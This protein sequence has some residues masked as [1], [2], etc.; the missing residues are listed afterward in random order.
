MEWF[1]RLGIGRKLGIGFG[2]MAL[3]I[4]IVGLDG[5]RTSRRMNE[6]VL[7]LHTEHAVPAMKLKDASLNLVRISRAVRNAIIDEDSVA[8][9]GRM[10]EIRKS[11][12]L[13]KDAFAAFREHIV[14]DVTK[15]QAAR[16]ERRVKILRPQQDAVVALALVGH[17]MEAISRLK[18]IRPQADSIDTLIDSLVAS[19]LALM[20]AATQS[21][22]QAYRTSMTTSISLVLVALVFA[23]VA[24]TIITRPMVRALAQLSQVTE[25]LAVGDVRRQVRIDAKDELGQL[26][27]AMA[28]MVSAQQQIAVAARAVAAGD[29]SAD[30]VVRGTDDVVGHAFLELQRT[31]RRLLGETSALTA[32]AAAGELGVRGDAGSFSGAYRDLVAGI[33]DTLDAVVSPIN[34]ASDV[35]ARVAERDLSVRVTGQYAG[36]FDRIKV[37]INTAISTL[38]D[39]LGQLRVASDEVAFAGGQIAAGS[40]SLAHGAS[41]QAATLEEIGAS[42][43]ELSATAS[44]TAANTRQA[45]QMSE[46]TLTRVTE[47]RASMDRLSHAIESIKQSS[48]QT[49]RIVRTID[50]IAFQT[51]LLALNAAVEAAR[52]GDAGRGFAVVAD[53]VRS[54]AIRSAE[55][56]KTTA[57]LIEGAVQSALEGVAFNAEVMSKLG[58]IDTDVQRVVEIVADIAASGEAQREGVQQINAAVEQL[59]TVTQQVA[60]NAEESASASEELAGQSVMLT[61]L[62]GTFR[63][64]ASR[65]LKPVTTKP[66]RRAPRSTPPLVH[67]GRG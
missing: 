48:D 12:S 5:I 16:V 67:V 27:E 41:E 25:A 33:N 7:T 47:G 20:D 50:E 60:A 32:A 40:Q 49:A 56:A 43:Q 31:T 19:K 37:S 64:D 15:E 30:V 59:N 58:Q 28:R 62:I 65:P 13:F 3:L 44:Q 52:A 29:I 46:A 53:E 61:K 14:R 39:S 21:T 57:S 36:D 6:V 22:S 55:A 54:L 26:G 45:K 10:A 24:A 23:V 4:G 63:I 9:R 35:L 8:I 38:G 18:I 11:D 17:D 1:S 2:I 42:A 51:N 66:A 34:E